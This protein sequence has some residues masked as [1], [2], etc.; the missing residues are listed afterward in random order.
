MKSLASRLVLWWFGLANEI[1]KEIWEASSKFWSKPLEKG[2][3]RCHFGFFSFPI[4]QTKKTDGFDWRDS[5]KIWVRGRELLKNPDE[6]EEGIFVFSCSREGSSFV[7]RLE[8]NSFDWK[9]WH[10]AHALL[11]FSNKIPCHLH[12]KTLPEKAWIVAS[13][14]LYSSPQ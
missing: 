7:L 10:A 4:G 8:K 13:P 5:G 9:S 12:A 2:R 6:K 3:S 11:V 14:I 1:T